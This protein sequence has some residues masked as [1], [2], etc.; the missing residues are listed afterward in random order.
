MFKKLSLI[1]V[2]CVILLSACQN[3]MNPIPWDNIS[4]ELEEDPDLVGSYVIQRINKGQ[5]WIETG[6]WTALDLSSKY[7]C[8]G[9]FDESSGWATFYARSDFH[10]VEKEQGGRLCLHLEKRQ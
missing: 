7:V 2:C 10:W 5:E 4:L 8:F 3:Q 1:L 6:E 9:Y